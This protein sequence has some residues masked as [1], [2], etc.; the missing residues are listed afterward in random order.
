MNDIASAP[1]EVP[2]LI[3]GGGPSGLAAALELAQHRVHSVVIEPRIEVDTERPRAKTT[4]ARTMTHLR[5]W[6]LA[7]ALRAAPPRPGV[8]GAGNVVF[9]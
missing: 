6:G 1:G 8:W 4:N 3:V 9:A 5:R 2:V 7:G